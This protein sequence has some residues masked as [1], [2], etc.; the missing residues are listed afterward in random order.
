MSQC[1]VGAIHVY[2]SR[3]L[4]PEMR[5]KENKEIGDIY[6]FIGED[7]YVKTSIC[8]KISILSLIKQVQF[9]LLSL[10]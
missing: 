3:G 1:L 2:R 9:V 10:G 4:G 5:G 6:L 7:R 8:L